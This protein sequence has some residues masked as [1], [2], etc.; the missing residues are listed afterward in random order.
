M[1]RKEAS[2]PLFYRVGSRRMRRRL[3]VATY[4]GWLLIAATV[5]LFSLVYPH[6]FT[7]MWALMLTSALLQL[8]WLVWLGRTYVNAPKLPDTELDERLLQIKNQAFRTAYQAFVP[9]AILAWSLSLAA[10]LWQPNDQ[11]YVNGLVIFFGTALVGTTLP[12]VIVA[13]NEP[14]PVE[15]D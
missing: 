6:W 1:I 11:G 12:T 15:P 9:A 13:W 8:V 4:G 7:T 14:D 2:H 10:M 3:V 5:K